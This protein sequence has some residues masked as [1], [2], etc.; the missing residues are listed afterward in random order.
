MMAVNTHVQN[1]LVKNTRIKNARIK[2]TRVKKNNTSISNTFVRKVKRVQPNIPKAKPLKQFTKYP[3]FNKKFRN[4]F[5]CEGEG[6][7]KSHV[8]EYIAAIMILWANHTPE[9][10][11]F[12]EFLNLQEIAFNSLKNWVDR[13]PKLEQARD[14]T[15]QIIAANREREALRASPDGVA[16][17]HM[18]GFYSDQWSG[19]EISLAKLKAMSDAPTVTKDDFKAMVKDILKPVE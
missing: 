3:D 16:F 9:R 15:F 4:V 12:F 6:E 14:I 1:N 5:L 2:N 11:N 18:Q 8:L 10:Y 17:K 13:C 19:R 7:Y